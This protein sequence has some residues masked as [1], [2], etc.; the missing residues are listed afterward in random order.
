MNITAEF[1]RAELQKIY[2]NIYKIKR[3]VKGLIN[4]L[5][6]DAS[7]QYSELV[8][9][10][11][12]NGKGSHAKYRP[13]Y[14]AWKDSKGFGSKFWKLK[15]DL[16]RATG[17]YK[18]KETKDTCEYLGGVKAGIKDSGG[19]NWN[20]KGP[21]KDIAWYGRMMEFGRRGQ[22]ARPLF[23]PMARKYYRT[24][25]GRLVTKQFGKVKS[26]WR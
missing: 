11:I 21:S 2:K 4:T 13:S 20:Q 18:L 15:G 6:K 5:P 19:K 22:K 17:S 26:L 9:N 25:Y 14:K 3:V 8:K 1:S 23:G 7:R 12:I 16:E 24:S 10:A